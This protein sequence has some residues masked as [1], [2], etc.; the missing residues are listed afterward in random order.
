MNKLEYVELDYK[1]NES[2]CLI[3][4]YYADGMI[5]HHLYTRNKANKYIMFA[6]KHQLNS[7]TMHPRYCLDNRACTLI[8]L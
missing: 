5:T 1:Y 2:G 4:C 3:I 7:Y 6:D 8:C